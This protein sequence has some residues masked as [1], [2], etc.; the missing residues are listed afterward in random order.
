MSLDDFGT[1]YSSLQHLRKLPLSE[2]KIDRIFVSGMATNG[3]DAAI[4]A[5]TVG[6]ARRSACGP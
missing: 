5:S 3:D 2:V 6:L 1:G 4:V